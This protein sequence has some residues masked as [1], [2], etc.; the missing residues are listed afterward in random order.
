MSELSSLIFSS[1]VEDSKLV[2]EQSALVI[3]IVMSDIIELLT[4]G[5]LSGCEL[6]FEKVVGVHGVL[7]VIAKHPDDCFACFF[8]VFYVNLIAY[9]I[10]PIRCARSH[11]N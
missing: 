6:R 10:V 11:R 4:L 7:S 8:W 9:I 1:I 5:G 3:D 2:L